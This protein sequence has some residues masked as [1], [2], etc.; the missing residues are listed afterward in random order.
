MP[1]HVPPLPPA[2]HA[3]SHAPDGHGE[4]TTEFVVGTETAHGHPD[5][6]VMHWT[7]QTSKAGVRADVYLTQR[8]A[9]L[10][11][12]RAK[13]LLKRG[14]VRRDGQPLKG[15][16]KLFNG[17]ALEL[18]RIAPDAPL[19]P[20]D[21]PDLIADTADVI[22][23]DKPGHLAVHPSARYLHQTV[24]AWLRAREPDAP[25]ARLCH[26]LDRE[27]SGVLWCARTA[28]AERHIKTGFAKGHIHKTYLAVVR[29]ALITPQAIRAPLGQQENRGLVSIRMIVRDDG[30][31]SH[32]DIVPLAYDQTTD[33]SLVQCHPRTGRQHQIRAHLFSVGHP[34]VADKL[35]TMGD[36][37]FDAHSRGEADTSVLAH[38]RHALHA[39]R[40]ALAPHIAAAVDGPAAPISP[41]PAALAALLPGLAGHPVLRAAIAGTWPLQAVKDAQDETEN[42][43]E[44][45]TGS[46]AENDA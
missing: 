44:N 2:D 31:P 43:A 36:V 20:E 16:A 9:R 42:D 15:S 21:A 10:S 41:F 23:V 32:T 37:F 33:R 35:Y 39:Y 26:R 46:A 22:V 27:T 25:P 3:D 12:V 1:R 30:L 4:D 38:P 14:D 8:F 45:D 19:L 40:A 34:I 5:A 29:G 17:D 18:W 11:R 6:V 7:A 24:T 13:R 28:A